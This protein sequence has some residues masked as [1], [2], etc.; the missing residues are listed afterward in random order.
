MMQFTFDKRCWDPE[1]VYRSPLPICGS[2][3]LDVKSASKSVT[4]FSFGKKEL[5][6]T[7]TGEYEDRRLTQL[8]DWPKIR[9]TDCLIYFLL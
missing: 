3:S 7:I 5:Q 1:D 6:G 4:S 9:Y 8:V 2:V